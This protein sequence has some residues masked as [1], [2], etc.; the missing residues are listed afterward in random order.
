[1]ELIWNWTCGT[2]HRNA[3]EAISTVCCSEGVE[4]NDWERVLPK[5]FY[6][7]RSL[8]CTA[9]NQTSREQ[10][11]NRPRRST[12]GQALP[13][14]LLTLNIVLLKRTKCTSKDEPLVQEV[15]LIHDTPTYAKV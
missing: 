3:L 12:T 6:S 9:T 10:F 11:F 14:W 2:E 8:L 7:M 5:A 13:T 15:N 1:M 4:L